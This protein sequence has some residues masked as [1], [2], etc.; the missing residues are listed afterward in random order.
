[1]RVS[2]LRILVISAYYYPF[3]GGSETHAR[4]FARYLHDRGWS[5]TIVTKRDDRGSP[6]RDVVDGIRVHRVPP[7]GPRSG[8]RKW[9]M[10]P[11]ALA[12][13]LRLRREFD[14]IYCPGYQGIGI[15]GL[16]AAR[17]LRKP[18]VLRS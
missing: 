2:G 7:A 1:M 5:V 12:A 11:F 13:A 14:V 16:L 15:A 8:A 17:L 4:T 9:L 3:Q 6:A 18:I 10:I